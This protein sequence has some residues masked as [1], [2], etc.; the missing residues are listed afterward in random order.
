MNDWARQSFTRAKQ[1][2]Y[3]FTGQQRFI[4]D[5]GAKGVRLD[6][7]YDN[8][9]SPVIREQLS[10]AGVRLAGVLDNALK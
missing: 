1:V 7:A 4:D 3:D 9:A 6:A 5:H 8:R 10:K 2:A